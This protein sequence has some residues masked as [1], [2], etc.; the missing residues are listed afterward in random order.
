MD[1]RSRPP[2]DEREKRLPP[3]SPRKIGDGALL[4][5]S[6]DSGLD[7]EAVNARRT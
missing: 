6:G 7:V 2:K 5:S 3:F 4:T 1:S